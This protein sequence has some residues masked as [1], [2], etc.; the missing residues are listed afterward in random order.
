MMTNA[1]LGFQLATVLIGGLA[2]LILYFALRSSVASD[3]EALA[4]AWFVP[5]LLTLIRSLL[6]RRLDTFGMIGVVAYGVTLSIAIVFGV[7]ALPLK[8]HHALVGMVIGLVCLIS[9]AIGKPIF[10]VIA[11]RRAQQ[12][13]TA[14]QIDIALA[15][16]LTVRRVTWLTVLVG[17]ASLA[18]AVLQ[19]VLALSLST[20]SFLVATTII[21]F[22]TI[23]AIALSV[24]VFVW[25]QSGR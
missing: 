10:M 21:H 9:V 2:P 18:N 1:K 7:G 20:G 25:I 5:V 19:T 24:F 8:L 16:P 4:I 23:V 17:S 12:T 6:L 22:A 3:T 13:Y 15:N 11:Q 14:A